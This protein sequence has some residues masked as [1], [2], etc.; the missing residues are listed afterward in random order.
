MVNAQEPL[1]S[2]PTL[3]E[4]FSKFRRES[5]ARIRGHFSYLFTGDTARITKLPLEYIAQFSDDNANDA[6]AIDFICAI[7]VLVFHLYGDRIYVREM[8]LR[9]LVATYAQRRNSI[10]VSPTGSGKSLPLLVWAFFLDPGE[11]L[12]EICP[13]ESV[14]ALHV[15]V[16]I[17]SSYSFA[18]ES[19]EYGLRFK[20]I[21]RAVYPLFRLIRRHLLI[22]DGGRYGFSKYTL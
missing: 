3:W 15:R 17:C 20:P 7:C 13:L 9:C 6:I 10:V 2:C 14:Q 8:Q 11:F 4:W 1:H 22:I 12:I 19:L 5:R 18:T 16:F 21:S